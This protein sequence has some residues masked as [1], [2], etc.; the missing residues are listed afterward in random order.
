MSDFGDGIGTAVE[1][2]LFARAVGAGSKANAANGQP[3]DHGHFAESACLNCG[4]ALQRPHCHQCGQAA[5]L[6]RTLGA[7]MHDLLH[8]ALH[9]EGKTWKT[10]PMLVAKPGELTRRYIE[11]ERARFVSPMALFLFTI[12]LMFA[13]FQAIGLTTPTELN[14][15]ANMRQTLETAEQALEA[16]RVEA[17]AELAALAPDAPERTA[18]AERVAKAD[19][20]IADLRRSEEVLAEQDIMAGDFTTG[21]TGIAFIDHGLEKW[22]KNPGLMLYK[23]QANGYKFSWLLIPISVPFVWML[24]LWRPGFRAYDHAIFVT[25]SIAFMSLFFI[26]LSLAIKAG[27]P[28]WLYGTLLFFAP[29]IHIY[30]QLRGA[31]SLSRFSAFWRLNALLFFIIVVAVVFFNLLLVIGAF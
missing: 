5:H 1:G 9:F 28:E 16:E 27:A 13:I 30:K 17:Q 15:G 18:A 23:L 24:F 22:Q 8:G 6:H 11:G 26:V 10:L 21:T 4:T 3:L 12:F 19:Q 29:P 20:S 2:G 31:Y 7:F 25:Y 14:P